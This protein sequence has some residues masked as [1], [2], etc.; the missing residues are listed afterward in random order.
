MPQASVVTLLIE[1]G[2]SIGKLDTGGAS[3]LLCA[4]EG[5]EEDGSMAQSMAIEV[6]DLLLS[7]AA[8]QE[9]TP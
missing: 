4:C 6:C 3:A 1:S 9:L 2:A 7:A 8:E 5:A